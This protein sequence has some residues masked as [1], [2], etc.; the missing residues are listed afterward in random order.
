MDRIVAVAAEDGGVVR[1]RV[2]VVVALVTI[3]QIVLRPA[4]QPV[5]A[6]AAEDRVSIGTALDRVVAIVAV[7]QVGKKASAVMLS[8]P[9]P[10]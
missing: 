5:I 3:K 9:A 4:D 2:D 6:R 10:P 7:K 8:S 1:G